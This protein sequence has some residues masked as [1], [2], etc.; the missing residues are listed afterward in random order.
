MRKSE[1][2]ERRPLSARM[3]FW[4]SRASGGSA[5]PMSRRP[6]LACPIL[7]YMAA[8][9]LAAPAAAVPGGEIDTLEIGRYT[10]ELPGDALGPRGELQPAED[11]A[12]V[13]GSSYR[14]QGV[15]GTYLLTGD[16]VVFTSGPRQGERYRRVSDGFLRRQNA[17]GSD[18]PLRCVITNRTNTFAF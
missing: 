4:Q 5:D 2:S 9:L 13:F 15:R 3:G 8:A 12:I 11:F 17:D 6:F 10:C 1:F 14:A 18:S 16:A 7:T